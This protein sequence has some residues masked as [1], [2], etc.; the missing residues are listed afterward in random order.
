[1]VMNQRRTKPALLGIMLIMGWILPSLLDAAAP[2]EPRF[3]EEIQ[4]FEQADKKSFPPAGGILFTGS[5]SIRLW[6]S[7]GE[8]FSSLPVINRGF[9]G[10]VIS[11]VIYYADRIILPYKP[12]L[13]VLYIGGNDIAEGRAPEEVFENFIL[14]TTLIHEK[15]PQTRLAYVSINPSI[16]R[17]SMDESNCQ[18]NQ[19]I[20]EYI[21]DQDWMVYIDSHS[22]M[23]SPEGKPRPEL[24]SPDQL[25]LSS[26][27]YK[28][29][30]NI[31]EPYL[32]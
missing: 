11:E 21:E 12:R 25:H 17:W 15:L 2:R 24:L 29:W 6:T 30:K 4:A 14:L 13:I 5:S 9:G 16:A 18:T 1:V 3:A 27:G 23:L 20:R 19:L 22:K 32:K 10:A 7:L 28:L 26:E 8:D 31:I